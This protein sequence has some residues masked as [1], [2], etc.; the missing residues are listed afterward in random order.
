MIF[1]CFR[2]LPLTPY[3]LPLMRERESRSYTP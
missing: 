1:T 2:W 3:P